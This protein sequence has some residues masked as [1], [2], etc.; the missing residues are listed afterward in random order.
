MI[1]LLSL[2]FT[3]VLGAPAVAP[4]PTSPA[5]APMRILGLGGNGHLGL[6][7]VEAAAARRDTPEC[8]QRGACSLKLTVATRRN[9]YFDSAARLDALGARQILCDRDHLAACRLDRHG[10]FD[11]VVDFSARTPDDVTAAA[12]HALPTAGSTGYLHISSEAVYAPN[13]AFVRAPLPEGAYVAPSRL[14]PIR[15]VDTAR[16]T[17]AAWRLAGRW[18]GRYSR[19]GSIDL[20][21]DSIDADGDGRR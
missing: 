17:C 7:F 13:L 15:R 20:E 14:N 8:T 11:W 19:P 12:L 3:A 5:F 18:P 1:S 4:A 21:I 10:P 6:E 2:G 9:A 16:S